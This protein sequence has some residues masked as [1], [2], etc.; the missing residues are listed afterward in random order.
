M[1]NLTCAQISELSAETL[2]NSLVLINRGSFRAAYRLAELLKHGQKGVVWRGTDDLGNNVAVKFIPATEYGGISLADEMSEASRLSSE[3]FAP[4]KFF[5]DATI[6]DRELSEAVKCVVTEWIDAIPL[7]TFLED[8]PVSVEDFLILAEK[9]CSALALLYEAGLC[10]DDLHPGNILLY[11]AKDPLTREPVIAFKII[12]TGTIKRT[13]SRD[14]LLAALRERISCLQA[15]NVSYDELKPL[16][17]RLKWKTP[18]DH[19]R[20][21]HCLLLAAN[22][23]VRSYSGLDF[24]E[25]KFID[26]LKEFFDRLTDDDLGRRLDAPSQIVTELRALAG[27]SRRPDDQKV[28]ELSS[29]FDYISAEM[30]RNDKEFA[31]L[32]SKECPWLEDCKALEPLYIYGPR[33]CGKSSV[34]RWLSFKTI[35]SDSSRTLPADLKEIGIYVSCSVEL[36]SRFWLL[37]EST[38]EE[39]QTPIIRYFNLLLIEGLLETVDLM[40]KMEREGGREFGLSDGDQHGFCSWVLGRLNPHGESIHFRLQGQGYFS[41]LRNVVRKLRW[42]TWAQ[43]QRAE[44][45]PGLPDPSIVTDVCRV[46]SEYFPYFTQRHITFL[47]DDYSNQ[48]IPSALQRKLNQTISFAKQG[49]PIFKVSSEYQGVDLEG[50][51]EGRE[52]IEVNVGG[53]YSVLS[54]ASVEFI[55]DIVDIRLRKSGF[56]VTISDLLGRSDY[57]GGSMAK[58]LVAETAEAPF[59]YHGLDTI[60]LLCSGDVALAIDLIRKIFERASVTKETRSTV[61]KSEQ[62]AAIEQFSHQEIRRIKYVVPHGDRMHDIV[63]YLGYLARSFLMA[64][65]SKRKDKPGDPACRTHLD[66]RLPALRE[67]Q[68]EKGVLAEI[69]EL[70]TSRAILFSLE[71]SRSRLSMSTERLQMRRIYFPAFKAPVK[72]DAPIKLDT[73]DDIKSLLSNPRTFAERELKKSSVEKKQLRLAL[74]TSVVKPKDYEDESSSE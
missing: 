9:I 66:I 36:R 12:D 72:R 51:Q 43:I 42:D 46:V 54:D 2:D 13:G 6:E 64:K 15:A 69:Y 62:H 27:S 37:S 1:P 74:E 35:I 29:P 65:R 63:C 32:F 25:R 7:D 34:L 67:L 3:Y 73:A 22:S 55:A 44:C 57:N 58:A 48:R 26:N 8:S 60:H 31:E 30:I 68:E 33:G 71:T 53:K 45:E 28:I 19:L 41:Y 21:V 61:S 5:G 49:T 23:L 52:V 50:I 16:E 18:D 70:L 38:I 4:I 59:F 40:Y 24:W 39:L 56:E 20:A 47:V 11:K 17:D 10:H 14:R